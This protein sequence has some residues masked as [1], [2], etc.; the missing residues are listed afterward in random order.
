MIDNKPC[1][2]IINKSDL[3][4]VN[5]ITKFEKN[6]GK[7]NILCLSVKDGVGLEKLIKW[8][9]NYVYGSER[10][11]AGGAYIQNIRHEQ[12]LR[13]ALS[14]LDNAKTAIFEQLP[15]DCIMIDLHQAIDAMGMVTGDTVHD[16]VINEIFARFCLGK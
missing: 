1:V 6:F 2:I 16:E 7:E 11:L 8:L 9:E 12:L 14:Y 13:D 4:Q 10:S 5:D 3:K 15:Y